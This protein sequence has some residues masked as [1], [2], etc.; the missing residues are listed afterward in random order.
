[1]KSLPLMRSSFLLNFLSKMKGQKARNQITK[2]SKE[3]DAN[4][5][6]Q[7]KKGYTKEQTL[8]NSKRVYVKPK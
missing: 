1:M 6:Q 7:E 2:Q 3:L 4:K 8:L 5:R